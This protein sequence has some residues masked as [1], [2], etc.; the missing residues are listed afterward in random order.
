MT[1]VSLQPR[2]R[3]AV[4]PEQNN[5][6]KINISMSDLEIE[7]SY[8]GALHHPSFLFRI[9]LCFTPSF[10]LKEEEEEDFA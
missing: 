8:T 6:M 9:K 10:G 7:Y 2:T 5:V 3:Y 1:C 4:A